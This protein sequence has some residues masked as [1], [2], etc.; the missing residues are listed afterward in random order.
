MQQFFSLA[1]LNVNLLQN[2]TGGQ[3]LL[4]RL[5]LQCSLFMH[6]ITVSISPSSAVSHLKSNRVLNNDKMYHHLN[7]IL[8][9]VEYNYL[10]ILCH[11]LGGEVTA[12]PTDYFIIAEILFA[13]QSIQYKTN[14]HYTSILFLNVI[15]YN[16]FVL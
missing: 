9:T 4:Q 12:L 10:L 3:L 6:Y 8:L 1:V 7:V 15:F 2:A 14:L 13:Q 16:G 5:H 11:G